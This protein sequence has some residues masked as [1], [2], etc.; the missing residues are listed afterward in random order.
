VLVTSAHQALGALILAMTS[1]LAAFS[2]RMVAS[3]E[4]VA[5]PLTPTASKA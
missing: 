4:T 2:L 3:G 5:E 1:M